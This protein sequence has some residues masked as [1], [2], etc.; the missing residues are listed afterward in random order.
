MPFKATGKFFKCK[1]CEKPAKVNYHG[2]KRRHKGYLKTCGSEECLQRQYKDQSVN[3]KKAYISK[4]IRIKCEH[5]N[6]DFIKESVT[7]K[8]CKECVP[9]NKA[10]AIIQRYKINNKEY[11][12]LINEANGECPICMKNKATVVDHDHKTDKVRGFICQHCNTALNLVENEEALERAI[13]Y[14]RREL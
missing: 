6:K 2:I 8:W 3:Q 7:Q 4:N 14:I 5:C 10:R 12:D 11:L 9:N 1:Y 13:L